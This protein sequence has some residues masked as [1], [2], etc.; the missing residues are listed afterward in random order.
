V[1]NR[2]KIGTLTFKSLIN[3]ITKNLK[4]LKIGHL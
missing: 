4:N 1:R 2:R 3:K